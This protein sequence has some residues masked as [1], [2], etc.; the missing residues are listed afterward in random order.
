MRDAYKEVE[1]DPKRDVK[2]PLVEYMQEIRPNVI[3]DFRKAKA[4]LDNGH[5][6]VDSC[7]DLSGHTHLASCTISYQPSNRPVTWTGET[8][9]YHLDAV[10]ASARIVISEKA[11]TVHFGKRAHNPFLLGAGFPSTDIAVPWWK[12]RHLR[13]YPSGEPRPLRRTARRHR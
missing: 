1:K 11:V 12:G 13:L 5:V 10:K 7:D 6:K 2:F 3:S 9:Y 8:R 4:K